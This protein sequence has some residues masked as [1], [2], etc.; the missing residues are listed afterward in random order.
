MSLATGFNSWR[1]DCMKMV[2]VSEFAATNAERRLYN[3]DIENLLL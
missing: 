1:I 2:L 3:N